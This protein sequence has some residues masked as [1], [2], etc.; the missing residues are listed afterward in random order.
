MAPDER[1]GA[2]NRRSTSSLSRRSL[3]AALGGIGAVGAASGAGTFAHFSDT[4]SFAGNEIGAGEVDID[5]SCEPR[6]N[7]SVEDGHVTFA[8]D[9]INRGGGGRETFTVDVQTN[10]ARLWL[11]TDCPPAFDPLGDAIEA[12]LKV[13]DESSWFALSSGTLAGIQ[14]HLADGFRLDNLDGDAC[15]DPEGE[16]LQIVLDWSLPADAPDG[17]AREP[18]SFGFQLY[19]EQCRH[20]SETT[21]EQSNPFAGLRSCAEPPEPCP[22]CTFGGK[23]DDVEGD[24]SVSDPADPTTWLPIDEGPLAGEAFLLVTDVRYKDGDEAVG[25]RFELVDANGTPFGDLCEVRIKGGP[26]AK[27]YPIEPPSYDTA[28][29]LLSPD[30]PG[31]S[32]RREISNIQIDVCVDADDEPD[33]PDEWSG[34]VECESGEPTLLDLTFRY[35]GSETVGITG[36]PKQGNASNGLLFE[37]TVAPDDRFTLDGANLDRQG[38]SDD[39]V[40]PNVEIVVDDGPTVAIHTSC[41]EMLAVGDTFG[42]DSSGSPLYELV[43]GTT[44]QDE[45]LC[46]S[47][48]N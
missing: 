41:S 43:A 1:G 5:L 9:H 32:G 2:A 8:V 31:N 21:A 13:R 22:E 37:G 6:G 40:G 35:L 33:D 12:S 18:T 24:I 25:V 46:G 42:S 27:R 4:G 7:C 48:D 11:G 26:T 38:N 39:W 15:L 36:V 45:P 29:V 16:P 20:V 10:P 44:T 19:T 28:K 34:C 14:R 17:A 47:E 23:V 30:G 3:L